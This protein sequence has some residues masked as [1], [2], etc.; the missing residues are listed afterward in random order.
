MSH[1]WFVNECSFPDYDSCLPSFISE[2]IKRS[3]N[4]LLYK[5]IYTIDRHFGRYRERR[6]GPLVCPGLN[7]KI[8]GMGSN[9]SRSVD[10]DFIARALLVKCYLI[11]L[12]ICMCIIIK[13]EHIRFYGQSLF[14]MLMLFEIFYICIKERV[15]TIFPRNKPCSDKRVILSAWWKQWEFSMNTAL[16]V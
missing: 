1:G 2:T 10:C 14:T 3:V 8:P 6:P 15:L 12:V 16:L 11:V 4:A 5:S 9:T 7:G 13:N